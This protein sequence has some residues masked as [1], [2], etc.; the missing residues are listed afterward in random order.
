MAHNAK[1]VGGEVDLF[2][3]IR[4]RMANAAKGDG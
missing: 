3:K 1:K 4:D 2:V